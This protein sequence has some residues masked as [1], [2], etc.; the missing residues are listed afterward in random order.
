MASRKSRYQLRTFLEAIADHELY[1]LYF[2]AA[3]TGMRRGEL[4]GLRWRNIDLD[5]ARLAVNRQI[6]S[7]GYQLIEDDL[8]TASSRR[9]IDLD[10]QTV[11]M[12]RRHRRHQL[13]Q[14]MATGRRGDDGF[15]FASSDG[16]PVHP[17]LISQTF[18]RFMAQIDLPKIRLHDLRHTHATILLQENIHPKVVSERL[19]H[20]SIAFTMTVYQHVMPGMQA[21]AAATFGA[22]VFGN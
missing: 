20:S 13:E 2:L 22:A 6:V 21:E 10:E 1:P 4:A 12:L 18:Q 8:K 15:V 9:T 7:V 16:S 11:A 14:R 5:A 19:G 3:T 17:D